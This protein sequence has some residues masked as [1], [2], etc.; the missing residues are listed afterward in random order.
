MQWYR[1]YTWKKSLEG[2]AMSCGTHIFNCREQLAITYLSKKRLLLVESTQKQSEN[3]VQGCIA[4]T[5]TVLVAAT[6]VSIWNHQ[7]ITC[8]SVSILLEL[9]GTVWLCSRWHSSV[10]GHKFSSPES[11]EQASCVLY[12]YWTVPVSLAACIPGCLYP[13][14]PVSPSNLVSF[15][16]PFR[17]NQEGVW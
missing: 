15:P 16:D 9:Q 7:E 4:P 1:L 8:G 14:L 13:W 11:L 12:I 10:H 3:E 17:K 5:N 6:M 2:C